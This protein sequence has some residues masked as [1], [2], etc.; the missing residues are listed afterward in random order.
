MGRAVAFRIRPASRSTG[1]VIKGKRIMTNAHVV[2]WA[3]Q[4]LVHRYQD[5]RPYVA[6][7]EFIGHDCDLAVLT[8]EDKRFFENL[9]PLDFG[10][11][12]KVRSAVLTYGYPAGAKRFLTR[13]AGLTYPIGAVC[14]HR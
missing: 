14:A 9:E 6:E 10:D 7:V 5:P 3:R 13:A 1:F 4:I 11:L 12:P 2:S 8:V